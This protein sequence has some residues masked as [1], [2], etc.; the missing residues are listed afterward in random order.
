MGCFLSFLKLNRLFAEISSSG[1]DLKSFGHDEQIKELQKYDHVWHLISANECVQISRESFF[2][3]LNDKIGQKVFDYLIYNKKLTADLNKELNSTNQFNPTSKGS[4]RIAAN[5][6]YV[7]L[8]SLTHILAYAFSIKSGGHLTTLS[9]NKDKSG[10]YKKDETYLKLKKICN[11]ITK[12]TSKD[13]RRYFDKQIP[14]IEITHYINVYSPIASDIICDLIINFRNYSVEKIQCK[15]LCATLAIDLIKTRQIAF[16]KLLIKCVDHNLRLHFADEKLK[17]EVQS[18][19]YVESTPLD[20]ATISKMKAAKFKSKKIIQDLENKNNI[21]KIEITELV[22]HTISAFEVMLGHA[23]V[24]PYKNIRRTIA[25]YRDNDSVYF[26]TENR[27]EYRER[28][29]KP[30][31]AL[32]ETSPEN[33]PDNKS[34]PLPT[35]ILPKP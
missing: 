18:A 30:L 31:K 3:E 17:D 35:G 23:P 1:F 32:T 19:R 13:L 16:R 9:K 15:L 22:G 14:H 4:L 27:Y 8:S 33:K 5:Q 12:G 20:A 10:D 11:K 28:A 29:Q 24:T 34:L 6:T 26:F 21:I 7:I 25:E 2:N